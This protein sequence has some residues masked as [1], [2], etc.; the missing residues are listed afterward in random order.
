MELKQNTTFF[1]ALSSTG[2]LHYILKG[3]GQTDRKK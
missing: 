3:F 2:G 1:A